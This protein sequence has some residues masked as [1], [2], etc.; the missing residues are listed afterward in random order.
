VITIVVGSTPFGLTPGDGG[1]PAVV[2]GGRTSGALSPRGSDASTI[3]DLFWFM[4]VLAAVVFVLVLVALIVGLRRRST[5]TDDD[6]RRLGTAASSTGTSTGMSTG[7]RRWIVGG[8]VVLPVVVIGAVLGATLV[9][10]RDVVATDDDAELTVEVIGHQYWWEVRY[11]DSGVVTANEVH[12]P[13]DTPVEI[14]L[15]SADV[16]H[17]FWV[18]SVAGKMDLLP[19]RANR[20]VIEADAGLHDGRCAEFCGT[21]HANM[22]FVLVAHDATG[23]DEWLAAMSESA[24]EPA[25][26]A[27]RRGIELFTRA[28][29]GSCHAVAGTEATGG[30][31]VP[32]PDLTHLASRRS[33]LGGAA[34]PTAPDLIDWITDPHA[35]KPDVDMPAADLTDDEIAD[36]VAYLLELE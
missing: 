13:A 25:S 29:C 9:A 35:V 23:F 15:R 5:A 19:E 20:I 3:A 6:L 16:I 8:G 27:A 34:D 18:P 36:V 11:P 10:M 2:L 32:A 1:Y 21:S 28:G 14:L 33:I 30:G 17:S 4:L 31:V 12:V 22:D 7:S 26:D 24:A